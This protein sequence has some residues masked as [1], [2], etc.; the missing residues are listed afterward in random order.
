MIKKIAVG[1]FALAM[2]MMASAAGGGYHLDSANID[3]GNEAS[4]QR[5]ARTFVNYCM[6]CHGLKYMRYNRMAKD[7][8]LPEEAVFDNLIFTTDKSGERSKVGSLMTNTMTV[9]YAKEVFGTAPPDLS[10]IARSRGVDWLYTYMRTFY[11]DESRPVGVNNAVF[12]GVGMPHVLWEL[13]GVQKPVYEEHDGKQALVGF[14]IVQEGSMNEREY[15]KLV[16]DLVNFLDYA[17]E[18]YKKDRQRFG[19]LALLFLFV[20]TWFAHKLYKEYW[21]DVRK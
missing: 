19:M 11:V 2:P 14:E 8:G 5:G 9:D 3:S 12:P 17:A 18:P 1:L 20:F 7:L 4:L 10:L 21:K 16:R 13:Q 15:N 6:G